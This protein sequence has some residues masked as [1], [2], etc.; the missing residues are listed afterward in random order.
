M[1]ITITRNGWATLSRAALI[2]GVVGL[3]VW[4]VW[5]VL[6]EGGVGVEGL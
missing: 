5:S 1:G 6:G 3:G 4:H 2:L